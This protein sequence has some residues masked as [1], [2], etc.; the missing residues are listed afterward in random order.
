MSQKR[1]A[2]STKIELESE[3]DKKKGADV[4][5]YSVFKLNFPFSIR[6]KKSKMNLFLNKRLHSV[7]YVIT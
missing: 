2:I 1:I 6:H 4:F 7:D 3:S 5:T